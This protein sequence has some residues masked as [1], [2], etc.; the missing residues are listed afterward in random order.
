MRRVRDQRTRTPDA[1][2]RGDYKMDM[3]LTAALFQMAMGIPAQSKEVIFGILFSDMM[4]AF[5]MT[6][7]DIATH[8]ATADLLMDASVSQKDA[9]QELQRLAADAAASRSDA[10]KGILSRLVRDSRAWSAIRTDGIRICRIAAD[11][12][13]MPQ[14]TAFPRFKE[15]GDETN[16][17]QS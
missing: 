12:D 4:L 15:A 6:P 2:L 1:C 7:E 14:V 5:L 10:A 11:A 3:L 17:N 13:G 8:A 16:D 9:F